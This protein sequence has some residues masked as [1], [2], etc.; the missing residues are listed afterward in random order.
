M[1]GEVKGALGCIFSGSEPWS[2]GGA[3][4]DPRG[5]ETGSDALS[6]PEPGHFPTGRECCATSMRK[7]ELRKGMRRGEKFIQERIIVT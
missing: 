5:T 1:A 2:W 4:G 7:A 6:E 3:Q